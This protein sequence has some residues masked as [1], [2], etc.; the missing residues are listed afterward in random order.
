MRPSQRATRSGGRARPRAGTRR[1]RAAPAPV[2]AIC[3]IPEATESGPA[4]TRC[5]R[6]TDRV[7]DGGEVCAYLVSGERLVRVVHTVEGGFMRE[8]YNPAYPARLVEQTEV[9]AMHAIVYSRRGRS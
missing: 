5:F 6:R 4:A 7:R 9:Q 8:P 1:D 3:K 2:L